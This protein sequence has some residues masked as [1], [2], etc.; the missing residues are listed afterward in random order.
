M[1]FHKPFFNCD[2]NKNGRRIGKC[3]GLGCKLFELLFSFNSIDLFYSHGH[4]Y[5]EVFPHD[6]S[7]GTFPF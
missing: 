7:A 3:A 5:T 4:L 1:Y 2:V 6:I